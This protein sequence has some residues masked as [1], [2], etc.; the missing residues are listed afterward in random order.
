MTIASDSNLYCGHSLDQDGDHYSEKHTE[1]RQIQYPTA[2][3]QGIKI[4]CLLH[5]KPV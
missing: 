3:G 4:A 5:I 2:K 1:A